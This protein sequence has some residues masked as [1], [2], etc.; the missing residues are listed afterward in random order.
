MSDTHIKKKYIHWHLCSG[1]Y[2]KLK[3]IAENFIKLV[4]RL[5]EEKK[6]K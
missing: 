3:I 1:K 4:D 5:K 6:T 2:V